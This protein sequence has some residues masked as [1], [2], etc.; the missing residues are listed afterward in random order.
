MKSRARGESLLRFAC[1][2]GPP[3]PGSLPTVL[4]KQGHELESHRRM[5]KVN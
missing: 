5:I 2:L 3:L 1:V 4:V